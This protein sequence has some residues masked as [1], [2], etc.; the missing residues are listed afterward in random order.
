[1]VL[2]SKGHGPCRMFGRSKANTLTSFADDGANVCLSPVQPGTRRSASGV[3]AVA[4]CTPVGGWVTRQHGLSQIATTSTCSSTTATPRPPSEKVD[5]PLKLDEILFR[6][7]PI[8]TAP[9]QTAKAATTGQAY[10]RV[11]DMLSHVG[12]RRE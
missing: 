10:T 11:V 4:A 5:M 6:H 12:S 1:M 8:S 7:Q 2:Y 3:L 9:P